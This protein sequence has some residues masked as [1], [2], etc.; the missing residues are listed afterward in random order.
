MVGYSRTTLIDNLNDLTLLYSTTLDTFN[1]YTFSH[2]YISS[3][4]WTLRP[5]KSWSLV[6]F[7]LTGAESNCTN[8]KITDLV[9][10]LTE[11]SG[12]GPQPNF[13]IMK[14]EQSIRMAHADL[15]ALNTPKNNVNNIRLF[16]MHAL[17]ATVLA[18]RDSQYDRTSPHQVMDMWQASIGS[19]LKNFLVCCLKT[20][21]RRR[22]FKFLMW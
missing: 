14:H 3:H 5:M 7:L 16:L 20:E 1:L 4:L 13:F 6:Q 21:S 19:L 15:S 10:N 17:R 12:I 2:S 22:R 9:V 8:D 11:P 18:I